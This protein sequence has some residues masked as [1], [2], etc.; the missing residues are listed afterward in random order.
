MEEMNVQTLFNSPLEMGLRLLFVFKNTKKHSF[1]LQ[2]LIYYNY[3][4]VHS[5]DIP[6]AP[7]SLHPD[8]PNRSCEI[9][10]SREI[11]SNGLNLLL[12]KGLLCVEYKKS[13]VKYKKND[14][15]TAFLDYLE[16][17]YS[18]ELNERAIWVCNEFDEI[19]DRKL[20]KFIHA[21]LGKWGSEFS[22]E[23][24]LMGGE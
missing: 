14:N 19:G 8:L 10:I 15:T 2:R 24:R 16:S 3:L 21:R 20:D 23:Y 12:S 13:G 1:D 4:L 5:S 6:S 18:K 22:R 11:V 7:K 9:V 17:K